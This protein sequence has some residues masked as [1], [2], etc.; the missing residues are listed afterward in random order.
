[1]GLFSFVGDILGGGQEAPATPDPYATADAQ[2]QANLKAAKQQA[3]LN[4]T[5]SLTPFGSNTWTNSGDT[6]TNTQS[7]SPE[8]QAIYSALLGNAKSTLS[9]GMDLSGVQGWKTLSDTMGEGSLEDYQKSISD[10]LYNQSVSRLDPRYTNMGNDLESSL[11]A[12]GITQGS[13]AYDRAKNEF[14]NDRTDA[15]QQAIY[16]SLQGGVSA[17]Q[18]YQNMAL[19][20]VNQNNLLRQGQVSEITNNRNQVLNELLQLQS[21][22]PINATGGNV[23]VAAAPVA[24]SIYNSYQGE[25]ANSNAN[26]QSNNQLLG[27]LGSLAST[28]AVSSALVSGAKTLGSGLMNGLSSLASFFI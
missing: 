14:S 18:T 5:N 21:G 23:N 22:N 2:A 13:A 4:R 25:L 12:Q 3:E 10:S 20:D 8:L 26:T 11:A 28:P 15:Y 27:G 6:W 7:L 19:A 9:P 17:G 24:Q 1:M 16:D